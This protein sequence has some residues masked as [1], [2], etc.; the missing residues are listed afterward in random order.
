[1]NLARITVPLG[2]ALLACPA[3]AQFVNPPSAMG[4]EA[5]S[6]FG[7]PF[8]NSSS[9]MS[10]L[11]EIHGL[12]AFPTLTGNIVQVAWR[13]DNDTVLASPDYVGFSA[14]FQM[15]LS[16][17]PRTT[18][19]ISDDFA[20]NRGAD[21]TLV[22]NGVVNF[23]PQ[24]KTPNTAGA[25]AYAVPFSTPFPYAAANGDLLLEVVNNT[26]VT[27]PNTTLFFFDAH[28]ASGGS[29]SRTLG[30]PCG[31]SSANDSIV[32]SNWG[33]G[34]LARILQY[35]GPGGV[36]STLM[37]GSTGP[38]FAGLLLPVNLGIIQAPGCFL[39]HDI[40]FGN[41]LGMTSPTG[42]LEFR[43]EIPMVPAL[44]GQPV[45]AQFAN[46]NDPG[47]GNAAGLSMTAGHEI[48]LATPTPGSPPISEAHA[49]FTGSAPPIASLVQQGYG[50][51]AEF[52]I[53]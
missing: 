26:P 6:R 25:F 46:L 40:A 36:T 42:R 24:M 52:T 29:T 10:I 49:S 4:A 45:R 37:I 21:F 23:P 32:Y 9:S 31:A 47:A 22:H 2:L 11:H 19:T 50:K 8:S 38:V 30:A 17:S 51:V 39:Q 16:T 20:N 13:R 53:R 15:S 41:F 35:N 28:S 12:S 34:T 33:P 44:A 5:A 27:N 43:F 14:D 3:N 1:M 7:T 18:Q 48:T